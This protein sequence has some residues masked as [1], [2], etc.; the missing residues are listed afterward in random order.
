MGVS[1]AKLRELAQVHASDVLKRRWPNRYFAT[2]IIGVKDCVKGLIEIGAISAETVDVANRDIAL[3]H[4]LLNR[5]EAKQP[6]GNAEGDEAVDFYRTL[7][8]R[9]M[10]FSVIA[11]RGSTCE[12]C[13]ASA[14]EGARIHVDHIK[15]RSQF[16]ELSLDPTNLQ[17]L[18]DD[19]N[20]GKA[21]GPA[22]S[23][24]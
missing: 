11:E 21:D 20:L 19:C 3:I 13:G 23:F 7:A 8:W 4:W 17:V 10:R 15:P 18:C 16:P 6:N 2:P 12:A 22:V 5:I 24:R 1:D 14:K 9:R